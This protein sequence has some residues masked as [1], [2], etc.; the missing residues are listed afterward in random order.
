MAIRLRTW[1][2]GATRTLRV[3]GD[4]RDSAGLT[5]AELLVVLA[6]ISL[7][8]ALVI[9]AVGSAR[10]RGRQAACASNLRQ[11]AMAVRLYAVDY[12]GAPPNLRTGPGFP[13]DPR[14]EIVI[15]SLRTYGAAPDVWFCPSDPDRH[16]DIF[17]NGVQHWLTSYW[18]RGWM[19][20]V[21][22]EG[23]VEP[24]DIIG[25]D[26]T[27]RQHCYWIAH[28]ARSY[29]NWPGDKVPDSSSWHSGGFNVAYIDGSVRWLPLLEKDEH[30]RNPF[31]GDTSGGQ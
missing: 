30:I 28:D 27:A 10:A 21:P 29:V 13:L 3:C 20:I 4:T 6:V 25:M 5:L 22:Y 18:T 2:A 12:D 16:R 23:R 1:S 19:S 8:A 9:S 11:I 26:E 24:P 31:V 7:L 15:Q 14:P 17:R